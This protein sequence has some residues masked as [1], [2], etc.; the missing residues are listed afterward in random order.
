MKRISGSANDLVDLIY[1]GTWRLGL[2]IGRMNADRRSVSGRLSTF[3][4]WSTTSVIFFTDNGYTDDGAVWLWMDDPEWYRK[5][6]KK[7]VS[8]GCPSWRQKVGRSQYRVFRT[9]WIFRTMVPYLVYDTICDLGYH[10]CNLVIISGILDLSLKYKLPNLDTCWR[11]R[12]GWNWYQ[13]DEYF[14]R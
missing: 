9:V 13:P 4:Y 3:R 8:E 7:E 12:P 2:Y 10:I 1:T 14:A 5:V 11:G 6:Q